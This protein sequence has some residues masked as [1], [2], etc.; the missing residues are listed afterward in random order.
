M[1]GMRADDFLRWLVPGEGCE[2][3]IEFMHS[4]K[5]MNRRTWSNFQMQQKLINR[6]QLRDF[7]KDL[8]AIP[9]HMYIGR[10]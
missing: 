2:I 4:C 3:L 7:D 10:I 5:Q 9:K 8:F 6:L 1:N